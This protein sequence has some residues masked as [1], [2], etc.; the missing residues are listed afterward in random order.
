MVTMLI[1]AGV[2]ET[3]HALE[4]CAAEV[5]VI[6]RVDRAQSLAEARLR[7]LEAPPDLVLLDAHL[8]GTPQALQQLVQALEGVPAFMVGSPGDLRVMGMAMAAGIRGFLRCDVAPEELAAAIAHASCATPVGGGQVPEPRLRRPRGE[9]TERELQVLRGMSEGKSNTE[10]GRNL[11]LSEDT[12]KTHARRLFRKLV[13][14][15]R[16]HA[17]ASAFRLGLLS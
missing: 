5:P 7:M 3:G 1:C 15:D 10:I 14:N 4:R 12:I 2:P 9:L 16:A 8:P 13:V 6:D 17:V 11:Y